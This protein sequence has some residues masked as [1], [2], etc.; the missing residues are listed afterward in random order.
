MKS[1]RDTVDEYFEYDAEEFLLSLTLLITEGRTPE[2]SVKGRAEGFH[3]PPA[4]LGQSLSRKHECIEKVPQCCQARRTRSQVLLL[5]RNNTSIMVEVMLLPD[6]CYSDAD[7]PSTEGSDINDPAI[8]QDALLLERWSLQSV[9][10][11]TG[12][13]FIEERSLLQAVRSYVFFSQL[14][15]WLSASQGAVPRNILYRISATDEDMLLNFTQPPV[16]HV[17]PVPNIS[18]NLALRV[19]VL[20]LPR[21]PTYPLLT[22]SIHSTLGFYGK[23]ISSQEKDASQPTSAKGQDYCMPGAQRKYNKQTLTAVRNHG[24][25]SASAVNARKC[26]SPEILEPGKSTGDSDKIPEIRNSQT[27][28]QSCNWANATEISKLQSYESQ[29]MK[30]LKSFSATDSNGTSS[31]SSPILSV[32]INPLIGNLLQEREEVI[33]RIA[34]QLNYCEQKP[35]IAGSHF[36]AVQEPSST[37]AKLLQSSYEESLKSRGKETPCSSATCTESSFLENRHVEKSRTSSEDT[38]VTLCRKVK[39]DIDKTVC[40]RSQTRRKLFPVDSVTVKNGTSETKYPAERTVSKHNKSDLSQAL[41]T[42]KV[43]CKCPVPDNTVIDKTRVE[44]LCPVSFYEDIVNC[45]ENSKLHLHTPDAHHDVSELD[46]A[47]SFNREKS[48]C[49]NPVN[50]DSSICTQN[51]IN[52]A[53]NKPAST[54]SSYPWCS[55]STNRREFGYS[56]CKIE[57]NKLNTSSDSYFDTTQPAAKE[58]VSS[59]K[60]GD[61][62]KTDVHIQSCD[63]LQCIHNSAMPR[64]LNGDCK[65]KPGESQ[66]HSKNFSKSPLK[67]SG[68]FWKKQNRRSLDG[69]STKVFHPCTGLPLLS[70]PV[71]PRKKHSGYFDLDTSLQRLKGVPCKSRRQYLRP[72]NDAD[73]GK[74]LMSVSAPPATSLSLLGNFEESILNFRLEPLGSVAGFTAEVGASGTFCPSHMT[75]PVE[76]SFYSVSDDNAPSPYMGVIN[77]ETLGKRGYRVPS[78]GTIQVTLFNPNKTVVKMFVVIYDLRDMPANHQTFLRQRT[79]SVP[80]KRET[81][82]HANKENVI[83][84]EERILRYLVHLRFQSSKSGKIYLHRDVRLLFS[85]KSM[86]VDSGAAYELKSYTEIPTNPHFSAR[87]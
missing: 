49:S 41:D 17:F 65:E 4:Q 15:A 40:P 87:C 6:C 12:D 2:C 36:G 53:K 78:S 19:S 5:W 51:V 47:S 50:L 85:R 39:V 23:S 52:I 84:T 9:P 42:D 73:Q 48:D 20:S 13:R 62:D 79:F 44:S 25:L 26:P 46:N 43:N 54:E 45:T 61:Q 59:I 32:E 3:C 33:A 16:E 77:L 69:V 76:V 30:T 74:Q 8:K 14:S 67:P 7:G 29:A 55:L 28:T 56:C 68:N 27:K 10:K 24:L 66:V 38:P 58:A 37:S 75:L 21:Q 34:Q 18:H 35:H 63:S 22:C 80:V 64:R 81:L 70:S 83:Q 86:E 31:T 1:D 72:E 57:C 60:K 71:P 82:G 11:Q